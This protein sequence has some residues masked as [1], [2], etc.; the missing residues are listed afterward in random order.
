MNCFFGGFFLNYCP[1]KKYIS[2]DLISVLS[3]SD[4]GKLHKKKHEK[5][6]YR[7]REVL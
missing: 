1:C 2:V 5:C 7:S 3:S 4:S 6:E